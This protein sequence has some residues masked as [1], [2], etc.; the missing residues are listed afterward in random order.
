MPQYRAE[1]YTHF[2]R[3]EREG[4]GVPWSRTP[5]WLEQAGEAARRKESDRQSEAIS[6]PRRSGSH[7]ARDRESVLRARR[8]GK[9]N[10]EL[11][12]FCNEGGLSLDQLR[13]RKGAADRV[14]EEYDSEEDV[15]ESVLNRLITRI[16]VYSGEISARR[17]EEEDRHR[18]AGRTPHVGAHEHN[19]Y[20]Q[21]IEP[22]H[23]SPQTRRSEPQREDWERREMERRMEEEEE[24]QR[25]ERDSRRSRGGDRDVCTPV[26]DREAMWKP[27][28]YRYGGKS[29]TERTHDS[30][31]PRRPRGEVDEWAALQRL[32]DEAA[33]RGEQGWK[34]QRKQEQK[35]YMEYIQQQMEE[36]RRSEEREKREKK[37][38]LEDA[39]RSLEVLREEEQRSKQKQKEEASRVKEMYDRQ[40]RDRNHAVRVE[41]EQRR[42]SEVEYLAM[43]QEEEKGRKRAD[44]ERREHHK[45]EMVMMKDSVDKQMEE[46]R[47]VKMMERQEDRRYAE[48]YAIMLDENERKRREMEEKRRERIGRLEVFASDGADKNKKIQEEEEKRETLAESIEERKRRQEEQ[49]LVEQRRQLEVLEQEKQQTLLAQQR[50]ERDRQQ[51]KESYREELRIQ[52]EQDKERRKHQVLHKPIPLRPFLLPPLPL[53]SPLASRPSFSS[54]PLTLP[55][56]PKPSR[57]SISSSPPSSSPVPPVPPPRPTLLEQFRMSEGEMRLNQ[58]SLHV[59]TDQAH[60]GDSLDSFPP[61][62]HDFG[63]E[64]SFRAVSNKARPRGNSSSSDQSSARLRYVDTLST[65]RGGVLPGGKV[66]LNLDAVTPSAVRNRSSFPAG[67]QGGSPFGLAAQRNFFS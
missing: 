60:N 25:R 66:E 62:M 46:R 3:N 64:E 32:Q 34:E 26:L 61:I 53:C 36:R 7:R 5:P 24:E 31:M 56:L 12:A 39:Q 58:R 40:L 13:K 49:K 37:R 67:G 28:E 38:E 42:R 16:K 15:S 57:T 54:P 4:D 14:L 22:R 63:Y 8:R 45:R 30:V 17:E 43:I 47:R 55:P 41:R 20:G 6:S 48:Q 19:R 9:V 27:S 18:A 35:D 50:S 51:Q 59:Y 29:P 21:H 65:K 2:S 33:V 23:P 1:T 10:R 52:M 11:Q 44:A